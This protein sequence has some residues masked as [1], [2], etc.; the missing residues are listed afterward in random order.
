LY[1]LAC[2]WR[3]GF[4]SERLVVI[5]KM[6]EPFGEGC[7]L[8]PSKLGTSCYCPS[9]KSAVAFYPGKATKQGENMPTTF[10]QVI[11][12]I[13]DLSHHPKVLKKPV[14]FPSNLGFCKHYVA[15]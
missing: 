4:S 6:L 5:I 12:V 3:T 11:V 8:N 13:R 2:F 9:S 14:A 7:S 1:K 10:T 15:P